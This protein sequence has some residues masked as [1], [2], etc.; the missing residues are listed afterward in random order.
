MTVGEATCDFAVSK[1]SISKHLR[2]LEDAG[3]VEHRKQ[4]R[5]RHCR[6]AAR[7][8]KDAEDWLSRYRVF[9]NRQ[10]QSLENYLSQPQSEEDR[11]WPKRN[12]PR[13]P[14]SN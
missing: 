3:L 12:R 11:P 10:F 6:L 7:P 5:S 8:L 9:W 2:V 14:R 4:G 13:K 1:P